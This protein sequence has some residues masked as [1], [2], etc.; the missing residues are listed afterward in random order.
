MNIVPLVFGLLPQR[1]I[2]RTRRDELIK[3]LVREHLKCIGIFDGDEAL[4]TILKE[5]SD[6]YYYSTGKKA[7]RRKYGI[8]DLRITYPMI[9]RKIRKEQNYR[10]CVCGVSL[11]DADEHLD[12]RIPFK[13]LG[14]VQTGANWQFL[15]EKCNIGKS[16]WLSALQVPYAQNWIY[17]DIDLESHGVGGKQIDLGLVVRYSLLAQRRMCEH[18][19]CV[20]TNKDSQLFLTKICDTGLPVIDNFKVVCDE[21]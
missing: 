15:C 3:P 7:I 16:S 10:C 6:Q 21:H 1:A 2:Y 8:S 5:I 20:K 12:H 13:I 17:G 4:V 19:N 11:S 9:Y 18:F 14:D